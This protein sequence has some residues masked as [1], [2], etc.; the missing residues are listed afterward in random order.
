MI[1][2]LWGWATIRLKD[3]GKKKKKIK[4]IAQFKDMGGSVVGYYVVAKIN[5]ARPRI[6]QAMLW[7]NPVN[8]RA[9]PIGEASV[10]PT[11]TNPVSTVAIYSDAIIF[12]II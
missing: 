6:T 11:N 8:N 3:V 2:L 12:R 10:N 9:L 5:T 7:P 1:V 4:E